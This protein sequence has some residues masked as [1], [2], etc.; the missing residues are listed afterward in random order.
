MTT[1]QQA[2]SYLDRVRMGNV[3]MAAFQQETIRE[4]ISAI[5][6]AH[7]RRDYSDDYELQDQ[8]DV[9]RE[10]EH[11]DLEG[12]RG[13]AEVVNISRIK[14]GKVHVEWGGRTILVPLDHLRHH[15]ITTFFA[16]RASSALN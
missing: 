10:P 13:P 7:A 3:S 4:R 6:R 8:V 14:H 11:K 12:W 5:G 2:T 9:K 15:M 1:S 16:G